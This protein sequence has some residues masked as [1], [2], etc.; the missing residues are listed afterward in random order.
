MRLKK[1]F[2]VLW[3]MLLVLATIGCGEKDAVLTVT[4][5]AQK[6]SQEQIDRFNSY[7]QNIRGASFISEAKVI[8][9]NAIINYGN[10]EDYI[11]LKPNSKLTKQD[12]ISYW[13]TGDA[14]NKAMMEEPIRLLREFPW[15]SKIDV[16][17][18]FEGKI[19]TIHTDRKTVENYFNVNLTEINKDKTNVQWREKI[20]SKYFNNEERSRYVKQF[21]KTK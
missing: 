14:I 3:I 1:C 6:V 16:A 4:D 10:Y 5:Q 18:P 7:V 12:Y 9:N 17:L 21:L 19:Y 20:V 11:K 8:D 15:L 13:S 2:M